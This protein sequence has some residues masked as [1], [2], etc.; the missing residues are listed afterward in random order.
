MTAGALPAPQSLS[1][2]L[3]ALQALPSCIITGDVVFCGETK[4][5]VIPVSIEIAT[6]GGF[7]EKQTPWCVLVDSAYPY[8]DIA[9]YPAAKNGVAATFP[10]QSRNNPPTDGRPWRSGKLCLDTPFRGELR[11]TAI[12]DPVG[13]TDERL[14][15]YVQRAVEWLDAASSA[16][17]LAPG[18]PFELPQRSWTPQSYLF[19]KRIVH[20]E[21]ANGDR[22]DVP[23]GSNFRMWNL[24]WY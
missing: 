6:A 4:Q 20:D 8:G 15:W 19:S 14:R 23:L 13:N 3:R 1:T 12:Q 5:W 21:K 9:I 7:I 24:T 22:R 16:S 18:D 10:H 17:L 11:T 2:G